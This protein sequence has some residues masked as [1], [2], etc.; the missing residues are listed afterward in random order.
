MINRFIDWCFTSKTVYTNNL[1][2]AVAEI[3]IYAVL[4]NG[5]YRIFN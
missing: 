1:F 5:V 4:I 2:Y 3:A